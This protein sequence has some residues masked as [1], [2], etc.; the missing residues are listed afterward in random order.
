VLPAS[1]VQNKTYNL[2]NVSNEGIIS[3]PQSLPSQPIL[4]QQGDDCEEND[5][6]E[7]DYPY[8]DERLLAELSPNQQNVTSVHKHSITKSLSHDERL[9]HASQADMPDSSEE[10]EELTCLKPPPSV[11]TRSISHNGILK[12]NEDSYIRMNPEKQPCCIAISDNT[13]HSSTSTARHSYINVP[14]V[15]ERSHSDLNG[16]LLTTNHR[17]SIPQS[18]YYQRVQ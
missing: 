5:S 9:K 4:S 12:E 14:K 13:G 15:E 17:K 16:T 6:C 3:L 18:K 10:Y 1:P 11:M 7:Y 2:P 8:L